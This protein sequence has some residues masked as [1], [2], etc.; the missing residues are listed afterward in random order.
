MGYAAG[1]RGRHKLLTATILCMAAVK[2]E[3]KFHCDETRHCAC[4]MELCMQ[5]CKKSR[6]LSCKNSIVNHCKLLMPQYP[7]GMQ[8]GIVR[9]SMADAPPEIFERQWGVVTGRPNVVLLPSCHPQEAFARL[10]SRH[11]AKWHVHI[12]RQLREC[13]HAHGRVMIGNEKQSTAPSDV[14]RSDLQLFGSS[15]K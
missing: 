8:H 3:I 13:A 5:V 15:A 4:C 1:A 12:L 6:H 9:K 14:P 10:Q 2:L 7:H 11:C